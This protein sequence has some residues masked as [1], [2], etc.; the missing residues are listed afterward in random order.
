M[1]RTHPAKSLA[2]G[3]N[4]AGRFK[5]ASNMNYA[6]DLSLRLERILEQLQSET[7]SS[8]SSSGHVPVHNARASV[9]TSNFET[10]TGPTPGT[11]GLQYEG[12]LGDDQAVILPYVGPSVAGGVSGAQTPVRSG[13]PGTPWRRASVPIVNGERP[14][15][16]AI[17]QIDDLEERALQLAMDEGA[18][19]HFFPPS[20]S[21]NRPSQ[22][23][24]NPGVTI[25]HGLP[26][27]GRCALVL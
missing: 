5:K 21:L 3:F 2:S 1:T 12:R 24:R 22:F 27:P 4:R 20:D 23:T 6:L 9:S 7:T 13:T 8:H 14:G 19:S 26:T 15:K 25:V 11:Y 18:S 17:V 10:G 16:D